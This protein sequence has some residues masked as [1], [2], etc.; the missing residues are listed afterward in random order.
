MSVNE[1]ENIWDIIGSGYHSCLITTYSFDFHYFERSAMRV[2]R[3]K[4][5][6]NI[7]L[8]LDHNIFQNLLGKISGSSISRIYSIHA[9]SSNGCFHP[10]IYQFF[11][12]KQGLL[13]IGSGNLTSSG[14]GKNDE[15]WGAFHFDIDVRANEQVF[16]DAWSFFQTLSTDIKGYSREKFNWIKEYTPWLEML[17]A[18]SIGAFQRLDSEN[19]IAFL[20]N[21]TTGNIYNKLLANIPRESVSEIT[22]IAPYFDAKG[23]IIEAFCTS[24]KDAIINVLL[25]DK[26]GILP[27][28][29]NK[30]ISKR[31]NFY[32]W[33]QCLE[34]KQDNKTITRLH[35]KLFHFRLTTN[36]QYCLF[37]SANPSVAA[38]GTENIPSIN[39]EVSLLVKSANRDFLNELGIKTIGRNKIPLEKFEKGI[40]D[41][42]DSDK[43][44]KNLKYNIE[45][46]DKEG[47]K[48]N[49]YLEP[50]IDNNT[51]L[52]F[53]NLWGE[54]ICT[55]KLASKNNYYSTSIPNKAINSLYA[56]LIDTNT[57]VVVSNKQIIQDVILLSKANPDPKK[58][59]LDAL[60]IGYEQGDDYLLSKIID[61]ISIEDFNIE[62]SSASKKTSNRKGSNSHDTK[63]QRSEILNYEE[64]KNVSYETK[65]NQYLLINSSSGRIAD[66]LTSFLH[67]KPNEDL[68]NEELDD[69]ELDIENQNNRGREDKAR[70]KSISAGAYNTE[71]IRII[72]FFKRY[73]QYLSNL[74]GE[75]IEDSN[76]NISKDGQVTYTELSN[77]II[78]IYVAI[79]YTD[80]KRQYTKSGKVY[81]GKILHS[82]A[83][84]EFNSLPF[85]NTTIIGKFL[86][87]C[88]RGFKNYEN[89][90]MNARMDKLRKDAFY[91]SLFCLELA[92]WGES[93]LKNKYLLLLNTLHYLGDES[94]N[95][96][97]NS[98]FTSEIN[99]RLKFSAYSSHN[100][101]K[102]IKSQ[103]DS[104]IYKYLTFK[105]NMALPVLQR[106][107]RLSKDLEV[108][109]T[110][111]TSRFGFCKVGEK[112]VFEDGAYLILSRPA[113]PWVE[114]K[115]DFLLQEKR[116]FRKSIVL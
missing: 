29:I 1:K 14:H 116:F 58:Q 43:D 63:E 113:F 8:F 78:A 102:E 44:K 27:F 105:E 103:I 109:E 26:Y 16:S 2:L 10:K 101:S 62:K 69:E 76:K 84:E 46:I 89:D 13:I 41:D 38:F 4:G 49:I 80:R 85:I 19:E 45:A 39:N 33:H 107:T 81:Y 86:L 59:L 31:I 9:I 66:S 11:G 94:Q 87:L 5:I 93:K 42:N 88:T 22:I 34:S 37:G 36:T 96:L 73:D 68:T 3:S 25:D 64:F 28:E 52:A 90:Y 110:V 55:A 18:P 79:F 98:I 111:F 56:T 112:I 21:D 54:Q 12:E 6:S 92:K 108:G 91:S 48:L 82:F 100:I 53:Y 104:S 97:A 24:F 35:A 114:E 57:S 17:P 30:E 51:V 95:W 60:L 61:C 65:Q 71:K 99:L 72:K 106:K 67:Q 115:K 50:E 7:S 15:I 32:H 83:F 23:K 40:I 70:L 77:Y 47:A 74:I 75:L 20:A